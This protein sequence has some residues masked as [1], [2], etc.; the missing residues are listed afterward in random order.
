MAKLTTHVLDIYQGKPAVA[1]Q[2]DLWFLSGTTRSLILTVATNVDGRCEQPLLA[3]ESV[4]LGEY[5]LVFYV[6]DYFTAL[7]IESPFLNHVPIRFTLFDA[8]AHYHVP[9]LV[10]PWA[11]Q[12]YRGS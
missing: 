7:Q 1:M 10:S 9:L 5:E 2:I 11:Y 3:D 4:P 12:T 8:N 6:R